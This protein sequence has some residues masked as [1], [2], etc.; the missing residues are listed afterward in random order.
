MLRRY[1]QEDFEFEATRKSMEMIL[2][3]NQK[4]E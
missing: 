3:Y 4:Q 1:R 2:N